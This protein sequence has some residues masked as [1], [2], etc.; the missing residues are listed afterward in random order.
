MGKTRANYNWKNTG[1]PVVYDKTTVESIV[2]MFPITFYDD[3]L[4]ADIVIPPFGTAESGCKWVYKDVSAAGAPTVAKKADIVNGVIECALAAN[5]EVET[6]EVNMDDQLSFSIAQGLIFEARITCSVLPAASAARGVFGMAGVFVAEGAAHRVA[7]EILTGGTINA[8]CDD[9]V[10]DTS[11][12]TGI[13]AVAGTY[14]IFRIDCTVQT[15]IKFYI[16]GVRVCTG[17]TFNSASS[18]SNSK[19]QPYFGMTKTSNAALGTLLCDYVK[20]FQDRS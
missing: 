7:F 6:V 5:V 15:D 4:G 2:P 10:T 8:E 3:F 16:D 13:T 14:N 11:A 19:M 9:A 18:A 20:I 12:D 17:T 1:F